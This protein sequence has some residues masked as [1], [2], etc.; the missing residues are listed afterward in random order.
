MVPCGYSANAQ[1]DLSRRFLPVAAAENA[2][3]LERHTPQK[4]KEKQMSSYWDNGRPVGRIVNDYRSA[5]A[6]GTTTRT[7]SEYASAPAGSHPNTPPAPNPFANRRIETPFR[8]TY[9][10]PGNR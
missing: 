9:V 7:F 2:L 8:D 3:R 10:A 5:L 1:R 4:E 6:A